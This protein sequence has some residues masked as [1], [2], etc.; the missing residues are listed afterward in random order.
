M[1]LKPHAGL[2]FALLAWGL[3]PMPGLA[4]LAWGLS[5]MPC[6]CFDEALLKIGEC[7]VIPDKLCQG[8]DKQHSSKIFL[9]MVSN[10]VNIGSC[11]EKGHRMYRSGYN[12]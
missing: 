8:T 12:D 2:G 3:S 11:Q 6:G 1:G 9:S 10:H 4:R 5:P 7:I